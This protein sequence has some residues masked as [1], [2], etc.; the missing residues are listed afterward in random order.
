MGGDR[1]L[2]L[3]RKSLGFESAAKSEARS[4]EERSDELEYCSTPPQ[5]SKFNILTNTQGGF[6]CD[7]QIMSHH[8]ACS[9]ICDKKTKSPNELAT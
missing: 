8:L 5:R 2:L 9:S 4:S 1:I 6:T 3:R 7:S